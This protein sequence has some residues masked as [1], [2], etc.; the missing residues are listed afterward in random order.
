MLDKSERVKIFSTLKN[1][2]FFISFL[3]FSLWSG[4][5]VLFSHN[6]SEALRVM[7]ELLA[8]LSSIPIISY[9]IKKDK[10]N[11]GFVIS[12]IPILLS[13]EI[14]FIIIPYLYDTL[15][16][17]VINRSQRYSG[18]TGN[19]NIAAF[20]IVLKLPFIWYFIDIQKKQFLKQILLSLVY[21]FGVFSII[22]VHQT[23]GALIGLIMLLIFYTIFQF[24]TKKNFKSLLKK[25]VILLFP[26]ILVFFIN[27]AL[28]NF[29]SNYT[30]VNSRMSS[31]Q[32]DSDVSVQSRIR[33]YKTALESIK[34]NP[35]IGIGIGNWALEDIKRAPKAIIGYVVGY[36][37]HNDFL[38]ITAETGIVGF[39]LFYG[40]IFW[41]LL[42]TFFQILKNDNNQIK[43]II[44][45]SITGFLI[46]SLFNFPFS[47]PI[48][49]MQLIF[50]VCLFF[51][52]ITFSSRFFNK[53]TTNTAF[54]L[55]LL[56]LPI[57]FYGSYK[58]YTGNVDMYTL[59]GEYN[60]GLHDRPLDEVEKFQ[61]EFPN[62]TG[63]TL[64][65]KTLKGIYYFKKDSF[66]IAEKYF[67][68]GIKDNPFI[69]ISETY[70]GFTKFK[71]RE[72][73]SA[74]Y[75]TKDA[76]YTLPNNPAHYTYYMAALTAKYDTLEMNKAYD[77]MKSYSPNDE[78]VDDVYTLSLAKL[79]DKVES[80]SIISRANK[81][82][83]ES[84]DDQIKGN[85]YVLNFGREKVAEAFELHEK[86]LE[87][88]ENNDFENA[89]IYFEKAALINTLEAPYYENAANAYIKI[90]NNK[91]AEFFI[92]FIL[93][94]INPNNGKAFYMKAIL[95]LDKDN[96]SKA[97]EYLLE[98]Y[99]NG[100]KG[101]LRVYNAYCK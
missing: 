74:L 52:S 30:S 16:S 93:N 68:E 21:F 55:L 96:Q 32:E 76:F 70:L 3:L 42:K 71:Q 82:L 23:R 24:I 53:T 7:T 1:N 87:Y 72:I 45:L 40:I 95:E 79:L 54:S 15:G 69:K 84:K 73:D 63:T 99:K 39:I 17:S 57:N 43:I 9:C 66:K 47:R 5:T 67:R 64:P 94:E 11:F 91:K 77:I 22:I 31:L 38:E 56:I 33:Y 14:L 81:N 89:A 44:F 2:V 85:I 86:G 51:S 60:Y 35:I 100:F 90:G 25:A 65:I 97:C 19:V 59:L 101:A 75:Y 48:Q 88:F 8:Y 20:S 78:F 29:T 37:V 28:E 61:D 36:H 98:S 6:T 34:D 27:S 26:V 50:C 12:T 46:D 49:M 80:K 10:K 13:I 41:I 92:D 18:F 4:F 58:V 83:L 62:L